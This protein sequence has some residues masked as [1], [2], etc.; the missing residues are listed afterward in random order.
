MPTEQLFLNEGLKMVSECLA[1]QLTSVYASTSRSVEQELMALP[2]LMRRQEFFDQLQG[3]MPKV[4]TT[5]GVSMITCGA[6]MW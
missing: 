5:S 4:L 2:K 3:R 1:S 6:M